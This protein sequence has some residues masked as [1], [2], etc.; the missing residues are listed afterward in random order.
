LV[1]SGKR[2]RA[3]EKEVADA[4]RAVEKINEEL[5]QSRA[6]DPAGSDA[7]VIEKSM[8]GLEEA[9]KRLETAQRKLAKAKVKTEVARQEAEALGVKPTEA[10]DG[11]T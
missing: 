4:S 8:R 11:D 1:D 9:Q 3:A 2:I 5:Q 10:P 7:A 6:G